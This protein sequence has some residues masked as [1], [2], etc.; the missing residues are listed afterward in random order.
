MRL[1]L[2][3]LLAQANL[4][5]AD[6]ILGFD[7]ASSKAQHELE[8]QLD[9]SID[10][11]EMDEWLRKLSAF[12][13]HAGSLA[14]KENA[15]YIAELLQSWGYDVEIVEYQVLLPTP[16]TRE[17]ELLSPT[18]FS[19]TLIEDSIAEDPSTSN[20]ETLLPPYNAFSV[21]GEVE[22]ELVFVNYGR[23]Q[24][25]EILERHGIDVTGKSPLRSTAN[26]G[27]ASNP[28]WPVRK[29]PLVPL[30]IQT[31]LMMVMALAMSTPKGRSN[32]KVG[33]NVALSWICQPTLAMF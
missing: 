10:A 29:G 6:N 27:A 30:F 28:N 19:A 2:L 15:E 11:Q 9:A 21:D 23:P 22:A 17:V 5:L 32:T 16:K 24:D 3:A 26:P 8:G 33:C 7:E 25:Y 12:P 18:Q 14:G 13:H 20:R 4:A 31:R 1:L